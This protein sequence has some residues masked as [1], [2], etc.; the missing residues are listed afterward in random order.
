M[1]FSSSQCR[2]HH[3]VSPTTCDVSASCKLQVHQVWLLNHHL[4]QKQEKNIF[5]KNMKGN[6]VTQDLPP[7]GS[8]A[9]TALSSIQ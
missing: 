9:A 5:R 7:T 3:V 2:P 6:S 1:A 8:E 4:D